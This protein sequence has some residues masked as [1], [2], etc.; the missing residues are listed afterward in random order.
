MESIQLSILC[1]TEFGNTDDA[2][3][4]AEDQGDLFIV[5]NGVGEPIWIE[6]KKALIK[7]LILFLWLMHGIPKSKRNFI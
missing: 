1:Q 3:Q 6:G 2:E 5:D 7:S 4:Y